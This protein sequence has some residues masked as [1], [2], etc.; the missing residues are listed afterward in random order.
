MVTLMKT[1]MGVFFEAVKKGYFALHNENLSLS[2]LI[3]IFGCFFRVL[4]LALVLV[5]V[6]VAWTRL[7]LLRN[8]AR[9]DGLG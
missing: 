1:N 7:Q 8:C 6:L 4:V 3:F 2:L 5:L 9:R